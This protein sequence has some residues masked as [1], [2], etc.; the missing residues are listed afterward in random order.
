MRRTEAAMTDF[1]LVIRGGSVA[2]GSGGPLRDADVGIIGQRIA[3]VAPG[4]GAG[5]QEIDARGLLV[6]PGFVDV[7]THF[8]GQATWDARLWPTSQQGVTTAVMGNCGVGFAPCRPQ[9]RD[10]LIELMEGVEDI[11]GSALNEGLPWD[12]ET[13]PQ[14][15]D[16][17]SKRPHDIDLA[18]LLPHGALRVYAMGQRAVRREAA[19][20]AELALMQQIVRD[21]LAAGAVGLSTSR[22]MA[23]RSKSG[24]YTPMFEASRDELVGLGQALAGH[25]DAVFQMISDF[26]D[27]EAEFEILRR[28]CRDTGCAGTLTV[29]Q[30]DHKPQFHEQLLE[31]ISQANAAGERITG[32]VIGRPVGVLLGFDTSLN[33]FSCRPAYLPL[34]ELPLAERMAQLSRPELRATILAQADHEPHV[35]MQYYGRAFDRMFP[36]GD[37]QPDYL[38]SAADSVA[39]RA[40]RAG[41]EPAAWLYDFLLGNGSGSA[42]IYLPMANYSGNDGRVIQA[43]LSHPNTVPALGD[44]GAH[45]GT[46]CDGSATTF[47]LTEWVRKRRVFSIEQAVHML[48]RRP[49]G[50][51]GFKDRGLLAPGLLADLN[52]IDFDA[53]AIEAPHM[54]RDLPAGGRR[55]LQTTRGYRA[56]IKS[57]QVTYRDG[58]ATEALP[59]R[60][61]RG[62]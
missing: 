55:F 56:T 57:G 16:A 58:Q 8:D 46:I 29:V 23:H 18:A 19:N 52:L 12:W 2:D 61:V 41:Q 26:D 7:H 37:G 5:R 3:A 47:L 21:S 32:Q 25:P 36:L 51:Y 59:G 31:M 10:T 53:L 4:L 39:A 22:T 33:P 34:A 28:V 48:T 60:L 6:T 45:V 40:Q 50:L 20:P 54:V 62:R 14:Y 9:D 27:A 42:L 1:D 11:P 35:F 24:A 44:G 30:Y 49:A 13:F 15:L 43:L 17:L 38:P